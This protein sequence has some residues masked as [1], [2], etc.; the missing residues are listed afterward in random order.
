MKKRKGT[1]FISVLLAHLEQH[2]AEAFTFSSAAAKFG[3]TRRTAEDR[4]RQAVL[5]GRLKVVGTIKTHP[6]GRPTKVHG[7]A[8]RAPALESILSQWRAAA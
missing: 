4:M 8:P 6:T 3:V 2:P 1:E 7:L 5:E